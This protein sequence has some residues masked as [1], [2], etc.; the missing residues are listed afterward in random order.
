MSGIRSS[1]TR[2][3]AVRGQQRAVVLV[4]IYDVLAVLIH[5]IWSVA[6]VVCIDPNDVVKVGD[7]SCS[8]VRC[9]VAGGGGGGGLCHYT[10]THTRARARTHTYMFTHVLKS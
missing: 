7:W 9:V 5:L 6:A 3:V 4:G 2:S 8:V 1:T 10:R